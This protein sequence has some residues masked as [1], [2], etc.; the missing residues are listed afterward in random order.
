MEKKTKAETTEEK[1]LEEMKREI[2]QKEKKLSSYRN[3]W[4]R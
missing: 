3:L 4:R 1:E 2:A